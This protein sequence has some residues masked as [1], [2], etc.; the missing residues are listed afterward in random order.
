MEEKPATSDC[1]GSMGEFSIK[2]TPMSKPL[3]RAL[4]VQAC[5]LLL[6]ATGGAATLSTNTVKDA[7]LAWSSSYDGTAN[8]N[9]GAHDE[10]WVG[11]NDNSGGYVTDTSLL[12]FG[13]AALPPHQTINTAEL[14]LY[15]RDASSFIDLDTMTIRA[16]RLNAGRSWDENDGDSGGKDGEGVNW[17]GRTVQ[18]WNAYWT[19]SDPEY[20]DRGG[21]SDS[22]DDGN[23]TVVVNTNELRWIAISV[24][25]TVRKWYWGTAE[26]NGFLLRPTRFGDDSNIGVAQFD[27]REGVN[28]PYL[29][30]SYAQDT[31]LWNRGAG[32]WAWDTSTANWKYGADVPTAYINGPTPDMVRFDDA[33]GSGSCAISLA[34]TYSPAALTIANTAAKRYSFNSGGLA[35]GVQMVKTNAGTA[36]FG[37]DIAPSFTGGCV[38]QGGTL[39]YA[40]DAALAAQTNRFGSGAI[41][42]AGGTFGYWVNDQWA[43]GDPAAVLTNAI[44]VGAAGGT[45]DASPSNGTPVAIFSGPFTLSGP[46]VVTH[47]GTGGRVEIAGRLSGSGRLVKA[48]AGTLVLQNTAN[49]HSGGTLVSAGVLQGAAAA[50][51]GII[52]NNATVVF[53]QAVDGV[54]SAA[55]AGSGAVVKTGAAGLSVTVSNAYGGATTVAQGTLFAAANGALGSV[56]AG[57]CVAGGATLALSNLVYDLAEPLALA[58]GGAAGAGALRLVDGSGSWRGAITLSNAAAVR[59]DG[60]LLALECPVTGPAGLVKTGFGTLRLREAGDYAGGTAVSNGTLCL[61]NAAGSAT[62]TGAVQVCAGAVLS[63]TGRAA[64]VVTL[65]DDAT[66]A[67]GN[68]A[69]TLTCGRLTCGG[70]AFLSFDLGAPG[71]AGGPSN[72]LVA[73]EGDLTLDGTLN[74]V[75]GASF[76]PGTYTL[77]TYG[78]ALTDHGLAI[79]ST[80]PAYAYA[81]RTEEHGLVLLDVWVEPPELAITDPPA[82]TTVVPEEVVVYSVQGT[83]AHLAGDVQ[84]SNSLGGGGRVPPAGGSWVVTVPL[85]VGANVITAWGTNAFGQVATDQATIVRA[86]RPLLIITNPPGVMLAVAATADS[87]AVAGLANAAVA[88][89]RWWNALGGGGCFVPHGSWALDV[90]LATG[91]NDLTFVATNAYGM[92]ATAG[93]AVVRQPAATLAPGDLV[94]VGWQKG[95]MTGSQLAVATLAPIPAGTVAYVTDN[96]CS[97]AGSFRGASQKDADGAENLCALVFRR[98]VPAG[99]IACSS[100][101]AGAGWWVQSGRIALGPPEHYAV[102][103]LASAGDQVCLFQSDRANPLLYPA[104]HV[105]VL[106]DTA[107]F[108]EPFDDR[109]GN[110]PPGLQEGVSA[111]TF[112]PSAFLFRAFDFGAYAGRMRTREQWLTNFADAGQWIVAPGGLLPT[113]DFLVGEMAVTAFLVTND[114]A[115]LTFSC[116]YPG[117]QYVVQARANLLAGDW[118]EVARGEVPD[119]PVTHDFGIVGL[120]LRFFRVRTEP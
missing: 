88:G 66:L 33:G 49:S 80:P 87:Y 5:I 115:R 4:G 3:P 41:A 60:T 72:D 83:C 85:F 39:V 32:A 63:G 98:S 119:A 52:T 14:R 10:I 113:N 100:A 79:G 29:Y 118:E 86:E 30:L 78:G 28:K 107:G 95:G 36:V 74:I 22:T 64:G 40:P 58:G 105:F 44:A 47:P 42:L 84:W 2:K 21:L 51:P 96:G 16:D 93:V 55:M 89:C 7:R 24:T 46:L 34:G 53:T 35:G 116:A 25:N 17:L 26:N 27:S 82:E 11:W 12:L 68:S 75:A 20:K 62:G 102:L 71:V 15:Y 8:N 19:G 97:A 54:R 43:G 73:V 76:G 59:V 18:F 106:D 111:L 110:V 48:G 112:M 92:A 67:P 6:A 90:A 45:L 38:V 23:P 117:S 108:E 94:V 114:A 109:T 77:A 120:P 61:A 104:N 56:A 91:V 13:L 9:Y 70:S 101:P 50:L 69:G 65:A 103:M 1:V 31:I 99:R 37:P 81:V 57:T